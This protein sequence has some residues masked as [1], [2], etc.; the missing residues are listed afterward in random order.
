MLSNKVEP[1]MRREE[2]SIQFDNVSRLH[3]NGVP[4]S[5]A[6]RERIMLYAFVYGLAPAHTLELGT[7]RGGS[8]A[9][10]SGALDDLKLGGKLLC[11]EP[12]I[13]GIDDEMKAVFAHNTTILQGLFP[14]DVPKDL[15]GQSTDHLFEFCFYD[16]D[17]TYEGV[18]AHLQLLPRWMKAGSFIICHDGY[19][20]FQ[21]RGIEEGVKVASLIDCGMVTR[22]ANDISDPAQLYGGMRLIKVPG[23]LEPNS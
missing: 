5:L 16:A 8:A 12:N 18:L 20:Q 21:A 6:Q 10:I 7:Y 2:Y 13:S 1:P 3:Q 22:C 4:A 19:N 14:Q 23:E 11:I 9:I 15:D 17:H